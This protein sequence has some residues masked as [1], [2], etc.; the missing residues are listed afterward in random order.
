MKKF[1]IPKVAEHEFPCMSKKVRFSD[2]DGEAWEFQYL[3]YHNK[4]IKGQRIYNTTRR[5][6]SAGWPKFVKQKGLQPDDMIVFY[7]C[8][9]L[10][11]TYFL[12]DIQYK[13]HIYSIYTSLTQTEEKKGETNRNTSSLTHIE[14]EKMEKK[15]IKLFG[16]WI[17]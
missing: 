1:L 14:E 15:R 6:L 17:G 8:W 11:N 4:C 2:R 12:I 13:N 9:S 16:V 3:F 7:K 10:G 5:L